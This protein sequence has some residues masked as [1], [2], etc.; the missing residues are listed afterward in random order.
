MTMAR[1]VLDRA[2]ADWSGHQVTLDI[3]AADLLAEPLPSADVVV[4][5]PP[6]AAFATLTA[7]QREQMRNILGKAYKDVR[8]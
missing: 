1:F 3:E 8:T 7:G 2:L 4:M 5:N 6:F